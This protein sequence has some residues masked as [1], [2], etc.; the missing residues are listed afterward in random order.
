M[1]LWRAGCFTHVIHF[2]PCVK[3][4]NL[5]IYLEKEE[6]IVPFMNANSWSV[7]GTFFSQALVALGAD[8]YRLAAGMSVSGL[9]GCQA[10]LPVS[11]PETIMCLFSMGKQLQF[12]CSFDVKRCLNSHALFIH[13]HLLA[14]RDPIREQPHI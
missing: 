14:L 11:P 10:K 13:L 8:T 5:G 6:I 9:A 1:L 2:R 12:H 4:L 3:S 7:K